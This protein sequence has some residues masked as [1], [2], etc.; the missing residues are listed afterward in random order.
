MRLGL[1]LLLSR[2]LRPATSVPS[3]AST[4]FSLPANSQYIPLLLEDI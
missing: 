3:G 1:G 2:L 4:T